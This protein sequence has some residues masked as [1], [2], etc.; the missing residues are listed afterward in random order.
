MR[1]IIETEDG[2][3]SSVQPEP[4]AGA[5]PE[6]AA[7]PPPEVAARAAAI[8]AVSAGPAPEA[9]HGEGSAPF[10]P[11]PG[12]PQTAPHDAIAAG[13]TSAGPAPDFATGTLE[14]QEVE[15]ES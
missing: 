11:D 1:I 5:E 3:K 4:T 15:E 10:I 13:G 6:A 14:A 7:A 2:K 8:G 12:T 9:M